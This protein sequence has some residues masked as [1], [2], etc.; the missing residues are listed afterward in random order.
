MRIRMT[1][2]P[3]HTA[4]KSSSCKT[5]VYYPLSKQPLLKH[6]LSDRNEEVILLVPYLHFPQ[7]IFIVMLSCSPTWHTWVN[8]TGEENY[9]N[10]NAISLYLYFSRNRKQTLC[11]L[12]MHC[13]RFPKKSLLTSLCAL[14]R[15]FIFFGDSRKC[16]RE[17]KKIFGIL[18]HAE[19]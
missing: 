17:K 1:F 9:I 11:F 18:T 16:I 7:V 8:T 15:F 6:R 3:I 12:L 19:F 5:A 2:K 10:A 4:F 14:S 13:C